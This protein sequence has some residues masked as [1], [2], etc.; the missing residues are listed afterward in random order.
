M[1]KRVSL[2]IASVLAVTLV[3]GFVCQKNVRADGDVDDDGYVIFPEGITEIEDNA[4]RDRTDIKGVIIPDTVQ[5]VGRNAFNGCINLEEVVIPDGVSIYSYAFYGCEGLKRLTMPHNTEYNLN[6]GFESFAGCTG[7]EYVKLTGSD[8]IDGL[9]ST[10]CKFTP[11]SISE[12]ETLTVELDDRI[13]RVGDYVFCG[14]ENLVSISMSDNINRIGE[15][16]FADC[17]NLTGVFNMPGNLK[18][19]VYNAFLN[20]T[21]LTKVSIIANMSTIG[22]EAFVGC[23]GITAVVLSPKVTTIVGGTFSGCDHITDIYFTGTAAEWANVT[24][25]ANNGSLA[26]AEVHFLVPA[27]VVSGSLDIRER[28]GINFFLDLPDAFVEEEGSY[29]D[30]NGKTYSIPEK[31]TKGRYPFRYYIAAAE[32]RDEIYLTCHLGDGSK[33]PLLDKNGDDVTAV[34]YPYSGVTY[35]ADARAS[36]KA[37]DELLTMLDRMNDY[38]L[39]AQDYFDHNAGVGT[40]SDISNDILDVSLMTLDRFTP[41]I[42]TADGSG[43]VRSGSTLMLESATTLTHNFVINEGTVDDYIFLVD[44][45]QITTSTK[46]SVTLTKVNGKYRITIYN[47]A[48]AELHFV[49]EIVVTNLDGDELIRIDN[50]SPLS[51]AQVV[52]SNYGENPASEK[53]EQFVRMLQALYLYNRA[54][55]INFGV[56]DDY[57]PAP[58]PTDSEEEVLLDEEPVEPA[59]EAEVAEE[60]EVEVAEEPVEEVDEVAEPAVEEVAETSADEVDEVD[61]QVEQVEPEEPAA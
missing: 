58:V 2:F 51:Y 12:A 37:S 5:T 49:H 59:V 8:P 27:R 14:C 56:E 34:G 3:G 35:T 40:L 23:T 18:K 32:Q 21:S 50:Y 1:K 44:G 57:V 45:Q 43:I 52:M 22:N 39:Y 31:D 16:A 9:N 25:E 55:V 20:C 24:I 15:M 17:T 30:I 47:I 11:W 41:V 36:G 38:G 10:K 28:I 33:Y 42:T 53:N 29:I 7:I 46:G 6:E 60:P 13:T 48:A 61:E 54:A 26:N 4:F 19:L